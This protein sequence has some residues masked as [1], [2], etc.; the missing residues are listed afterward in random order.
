MTTC[1][2]CR[3]ETFCELIN[4]QSTIYRCLE[5][6]SKQENAEDKILTAAEDERKAV[7]ARLQKNGNQFETRLEVQTDIFNAQVISIHDLKLA[8]D[9]DESVTDKHFT[10]A[11]ALSDRFVL[12]QDLIVGARADI[13]AAETKQRAIQTYYI[14]LSKKLRQEERDK[15]KLRDL[16]YKPAEVKT[17]TPKKVSTKKADKE[18]AIKVANE[19]GV[20][21]QVLMILALTKNLSYRDAAIEFKKMQNNLPKA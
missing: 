12:L 6:K 21:L 2:S 19:S 18:E 7:L 4:P 3:K 13:L 1:F 5:C 11:K 9:A 16:Q 10:L 17:V 15:L 20:P 14:E 8:I